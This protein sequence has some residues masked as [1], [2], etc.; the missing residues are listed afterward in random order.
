MLSSAAWEAE[1]AR[2]VLM[3]AEQQSFSNRA[4]YLLP[5]NGHPRGAPRT[6]RLDAKL[7]SASSDADRFQCLLLVVGRGALASIG[8]VGTAMLRP[9]LAWKTSAAMAPL[10]FAA[11]RRLPGSEPTP[12]DPDVLQQETPKAVP[13][14]AST[15]PALGNLSLLS[16]RETRGRDSAASVPPS[17]SLEF[18]TIE[19]PA[20][21]Y[22][23]STAAYDFTAG[24][25]YPPNGTRL[26]NRSGLGDKLDHPR[27]VDELERA[28]MPSHLDERMPRSALFP[29]VQALLLPPICTSFWFSRTRL[30]WRLIW[31][32]EWRF[33]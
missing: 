19:R 32:P 8:F 2:G 31:G 4:Q 22:A 5:A 33:E 16:S 20:R 3:I 27:F 29:M 18:G 26:E 1:P 7:I 14:T 17:R 30:L 21:D 24:S 10:V 13:T 15:A 25:W 12:F 11:P 6:D 9:S 23:K 28:A